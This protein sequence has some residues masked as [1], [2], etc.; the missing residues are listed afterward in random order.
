MCPACAKG[1]ATQ[2]S[3]PAFKS[4]HADKV[5]GLIHSDLWGPAPVQTITSTCYV[6][7]FTDN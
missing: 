7:T 2:A 1:E 3:F 6:I 4:S 5:L